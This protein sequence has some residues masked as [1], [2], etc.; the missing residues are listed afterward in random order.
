MNESPAGL[1]FMAPI[2]GTDRGIM[3]HV[4]IPSQEADLTKASVIL[5][6]LVRSISVRRLG[7]KLGRVSSSTMTEVEQRWAFLLGLQSKQ[8]SMKPASSEEC[9]SDRPFFSYQNQKRGRW[10]SGRLDAS[11]RSDVRW[12]F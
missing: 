2:T 12:H 8:N 11:R 10:P 1:L 6:D 3:A 9:A 7:R 4:R 5:T